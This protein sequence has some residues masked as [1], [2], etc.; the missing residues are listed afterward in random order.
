MCGAHRLQAPA[1]LKDDRRQEKVEEEIV[2]EVDP[3][4]ARGQGHG[5]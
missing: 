3:L 5:L 1:R 2:V 4:A